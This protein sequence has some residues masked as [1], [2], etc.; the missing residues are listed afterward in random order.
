MNRYKQQADYTEW[1]DK[2]HIYGLDFRDLNS[3]EAFCDHLLKTQS[4]LDVLINN[5]CQ[6]VRR[7]PAYYRH[8]LANEV[9]LTKTLKGVDNVVDIGLVEKD[10]SN[11]TTTS[12]TTTNSTTMNTNKTTTTNSTTM[13]T[14]KTTTTNST[15]MN[16]N[17]TSTQEEINNIIPSFTQ[18]HSASLLSQ[19]RLVE[20]DDNTQDFP[21]HTYDVNTQ[22]VDLRTS[23]SW[24][25]KQH[26][27]STPELV[28]VMAINAVVPFV[29][30]ARLRPLMRGHKD[31]YIVNVS[32][33]E[34]KFYRHKTANHPHTNMAKA[35]LNMMTRTSAG[36][37]AKEAIYMNSVDTG[38]INE[39]NPRDRAARTAQKNN[40][41]TPID[42]IDAASRILD[43]VYEG[44]EKGV[45]LFGKFYKDYSVSEWWWMMVSGI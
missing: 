32:A 2:L 16:T 42:E 40:F 29:L 24:V 5:A 30:N 23:N 19:A 21:I 38:W 25:L 34:G 36:D 13:N 1:A 31:A 17:K 4:R 11:S 6:T 8:L 33:M 14:N 3:V 43:P 41:Q 9:A 45:Y 39:E 26:E 18:A 28:E 37:Y 7:P 22:Q 27:V 10:G 12:T 15:T 44:I 35:A 20:G